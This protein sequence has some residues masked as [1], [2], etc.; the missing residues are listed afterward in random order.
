MRRILYLAYGLTAYAMFLGIAL[1]LQAFFANF[2]VAKSIDEPSGP[3]MAT[4]M[5][6]DILLLSLIHI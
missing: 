1:Y 3:R 6:I 4:A 5:I 2:L